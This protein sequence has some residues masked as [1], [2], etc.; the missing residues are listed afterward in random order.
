MILLL[1]LAAGEV[2]DVGGVRSGDGLVLFS[3]LSDSLFS[4]V[5]F[6]LFLTFARHEVRFETSTFRPAS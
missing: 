6:M 1:T 4:S 3:S 5:D 2:S